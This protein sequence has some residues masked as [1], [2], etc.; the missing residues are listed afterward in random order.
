MFNGSD[1]FV[2][3]QLKFILTF[4][5][6]IE[7]TVKYETRQSLEEYSQIS[8]CKCLIVSK[9]MITLLESHEHKYK[10]RT[11]MNGERGGKR[12]RL[13]CTSEGG[14]GEAVRA[15]DVDGIREDPEE[16]LGDERDAPGVLH[17]LQAGG[18]EA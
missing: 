15:A 10:I 16:R 5:E 13:L 18:A 3:N 2:A 12:D 4:V 8:S 17:E 11:K 1:I 14:V 6:I 7:E 9:L